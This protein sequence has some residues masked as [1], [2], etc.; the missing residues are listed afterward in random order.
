MNDKDIINAGLLPP[1]AIKIN[2][3]GEYMVIGAQLC[4]RDGS[5]MGNAFIYDVIN[6]IYFREF[7]VV[8]TD[9]GNSFKMTARELK[10][11]YFQPKYIM[12]RHRA[13]QERSRGLNHDDK[14]GFFLIGLQEELKELQEYAE[15]DLIHWGIIEKQ[16]SIIK[17]FKQAFDL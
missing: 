13:K 7:A 14:I 4:T 1:W 15:A 6:D 10:E 17:K 8:I 11:S 2:E 9:M 3:G 16:E 5:R 12:D